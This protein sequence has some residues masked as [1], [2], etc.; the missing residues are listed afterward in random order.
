MSCTHTVLLLFMDFDGT[1]DRNWDNT[2]TSCL[3]I[4]LRFTGL[5]EHNVQITRCRNCHYA[6]IVG[7]IPSLVRQPQLSSIFQ[8]RGTLRCRFHGGERASLWQCSLSEM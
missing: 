4:L 2:S 6:V 5:R 1:H 3:S 8:Q 7:S